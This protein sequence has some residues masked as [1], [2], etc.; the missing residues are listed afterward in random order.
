[1]TKPDI[2]VNSSALEGETVVITGTLEQLTRKEAEE[3]VVEAGG[4][5]GS[6]ITKNT[7]V[8]I[9][10]EKAGSKLKKA[11][12]LEVAIR[13]EQDLI[14]AVDIKSCG[15]FFSPSQPEQQQPDNEDELVKDYPLKRCAQQLFSNYQP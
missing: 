2:T 5:V 10:G 12:E 1:M 3:L 14:Q 6:S 8:L 7:T 11:K 13:R 15:L 9:A 4:K